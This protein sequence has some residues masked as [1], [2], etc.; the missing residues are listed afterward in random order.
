MLPGT[1]KRLGIKV[2]GENRFLYTGSA[3]LGAALVILLA[4][5]QYNS[6]L[7]NQ[8]KRLNE[9]LM[10]FEQKR[11]RNE[12]AELRLTRDRL[13]IIT[14]LIKNHTHWT[15]FFSWFENLLQREVQVE[16]LSAKRDGEVTFSAK[17]GNYTVVA[18][19]L[20]VFLSDDKIKDVTL[21]EIVSSA[22]GTVEFGI[23][24][25]VDLNKIIF[26]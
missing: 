1:K 26:K 22:D 19:Q 23:E 17:A 15:G 7:V 5:S 2:P 4:F 13:M 25:I 14:D 10:A 18:R 21:G 3:V 12:E 9:E 16:G 20:A 8:I 6:S 24:L 11:D